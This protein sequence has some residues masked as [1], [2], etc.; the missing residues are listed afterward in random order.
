MSELNTAPTTNS[1][2]TATAPAGAQKNPANAPA[3]APV[4]TAHAM[5]G[6]TPKASRRQV[7][8]QH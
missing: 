8:K 6:T 4:A 7:R 2:N 3:T 1:S 5:P